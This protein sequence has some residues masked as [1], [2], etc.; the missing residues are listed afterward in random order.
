MPDTIQ[1][2]PF[3]VE[4]AARPSEKKSCAAKRIHDPQ[5]FV[6]GTVNV[7]T[8]YAPLPTPS[9]PRV[10]TVCAQSGGPPCVRSVGLA[11]C[12]EFVRSW[13]NLVVSVALPCQRT[14]LNVT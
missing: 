14:S 1:T 11:I 2:S 13:P 7:S 5:G 8:T 3:Q 12:N 9:L 4:T 10:V 6:S